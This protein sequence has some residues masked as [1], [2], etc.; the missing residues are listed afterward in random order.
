MKFISYS[1]QISS[2]KPSS[3]ST[4]AP[5]TLTIEASVKL[6]D[7][8]NDAAFHTWIKDQSNARISARHLARL[9]G[10]YSDE[11]IGM[12]LRWLFEDWQLVN[13]AVVLLII[14]VEE[15]PSISCEQRA[16]LDRTRR[17]SIL[18]LITAGWA[19]HHV[20]HLILLLRLPLCKL[21]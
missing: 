3:C 8:F 12:G 11:Q 19:P 20:E 16:K 9:I 10:D 18:R 4:S 13:I 7:H 17:E 2:R 5:S 15:Q 21:Y 14:L 1:S 6:M